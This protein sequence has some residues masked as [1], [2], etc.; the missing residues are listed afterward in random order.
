MIK[1]FTIIFYM[2]IFMYKFFSS[3]FSLP[4]CF[5]PFIV[6]F[7]LCD[8]KWSALYFPFHYDIASTYVPCSCAFSFY[9]HTI[10]RCTSEVDLQTFSPSVLD[11]FRW[12]W[13][14]VLSEWLNGKYQWTASSNE[15]SWFYLCLTLII[16]IVQTFLA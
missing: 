8:D 1:H 6:I 12:S 16:W 14:V 15:K 5:I 3:K 9:I 4:R 2:Y 13:V 10:C 11:T 7:W